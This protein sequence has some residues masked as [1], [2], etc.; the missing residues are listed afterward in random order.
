MSVIIGTPGDDLLE[1]GVE[2][3]DIFGQDGND[4]LNGGAGNDVIKGGSGDDSLTGDAGNVEIKAKVTLKQTLSSGTTICVELEISGKQKDVEDAVKK[5]P[6]KIGNSIKNLNSKAGNKVSDK[7]TGLLDGLLEDLDNAIENL[8]VQDFFLAYQNLVQGLNDLGFI[9]EAQILINL[10]EDSLAPF[11]SGDDLLKGGLGDDL[12]F[13]NGGNDSLDGGK[14]NDIANGDIGDDLI[15]GGKGDDSLVGGEGND[16]LSAGEGNDTLVGGS[17]NDLLRGK[18]GDD[19]L[20]GGAGIDTLKGGE[21]SDTF[22]IE[23]LL[24]GEVD[25]ITDFTP[26]EDKIMLPW[27]D[28]TLVQVF[29]GDANAAPDGTTIVYD[30]DTGLVSYL[31]PTDDKIDILQLDKN[32]NLD[33]DDFASF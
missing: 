24:P 31:D 22:N 21:G 30:P 17:G 14:G 1:G 25:I 8:A 29:N 12:I 27:G 7:T 20:S 26:G 10:F 15:R 6:E 13:G 9:A 28:D 4:I 2:D 18:T 33:A 19:L 16:T 3:D 32:L 11:I 5:L 23:E